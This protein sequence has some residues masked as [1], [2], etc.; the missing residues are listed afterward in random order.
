[1]NNNLKFLDEFDRKTN[2][3]EMIVKCAEK[4]HSIS[5]GSSSADSNVL[6]LAMEAFLQKKTDE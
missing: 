3:Y 1:M 2:V 4:A 6:H 5:S